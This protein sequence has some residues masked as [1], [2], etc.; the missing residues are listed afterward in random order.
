MPR[1]PGSFAPG[2]VLYHSDE[3]QTPEEEEGQQDGRRRESPPSQS[4]FPV[5]MTLG[6]P[7]NSG[8]PS[9]RKRRL[10]GPACQSYGEDR[11]RPPGPNEE[12]IEVL[13]GSQGSAEEG[14]F[15]SGA[16]LTACE[17]L[18]ILLPVPGEDIIR[19]RAY[20][21]RRSQICAVLSDVLRGE[22]DLRVPHLCAVIIAVDKRTRDEMGVTLE[23]P[24][25]KI[26][27]F[28][29]S[30]T[31]AENVAVLEV[32]AV[33][34][35][36]GA[37]IFVTGPGTKRFI[38]VHH[39]TIVRIF[40][41]STPRPSDALLARLRSK[42]APLPGRPQVKE[43]DLVDRADRLPEKQ[44]KP[45]TAAPPQ[46]PSVQHLPLKRPA[47]AQQ[48][49]SSQQRSSSTQPSTNMGGRFTARFTGNPPQPH[50]SKPMTSSPTT[51][52]RENSGTSK[53]GIECLVKESPQ[54][55]ISA[56]K[57]VT[58]DTLGILEIING[59][60]QPSPGA[61]LPQAHSSAAPSK[62]ADSV[63]LSTIDSSMNMNSGV[64]TNKTLQAS[65]AGSMWCELGALSAG[66]ID[67]LLLEDDSGD[68][69]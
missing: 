3:T 4:V 11:R 61:L 66:A 22:H 30:R 59:A 24:T 53:S 50:N 5:P 63:T 64:E 31:I 32:G 19:N 23:D 48:E 47:P 2:F 26:G 67:E 44:G 34:I 39:E 56:A 1:E 45:P 33:L 65:T 8:N 40:P 54:P 36:K 57:Q 15:A 46:R 20:R 28:L 43:R 21:F 69:D 41:V 25:G 12:V 37:A 29:D 55:Q 62:P 49:T 14:P 6:Q 16:W 17:N 35:L 9:S 60:Q 52:S 38:N 10:P 7:P 58:R 13:S 18:D 51:A 27:G 68:D 42:D